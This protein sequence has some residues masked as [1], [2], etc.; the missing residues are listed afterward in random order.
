MNENQ[1]ADAAKDCQNPMPTKH[2]QW[3][4]VLV[5]AAS[6]VVLVAMSVR[7][8]GNESVRQVKGTITAVNSASRQASIEVLD[9]ATGQVEEYTGSVPVD[10][11]I[12]INGKQVTLAELR[13]DDKVE[14]QGRVV[15]GTSGGSG[16][17]R[18]AQADWIRVTRRD[19]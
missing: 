15:R 13:I 7:D 19:G 14:V 3:K 6:V 2:G 18:E 12:S 11:A 5:I 16:P 10:C 1:N 9:P 8:G 17:Y 4:A